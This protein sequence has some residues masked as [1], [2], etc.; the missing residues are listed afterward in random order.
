MITT[1]QIC[2]TLKD[3]PAS[4]GVENRQKDKQVRWSPC[5]VEFMQNM[6][7]CQAPTEPTEFL[8]LKICA[9]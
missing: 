7:S 5:G 8:A 6:N 3:F 1:V 4:K 2:R 9:A